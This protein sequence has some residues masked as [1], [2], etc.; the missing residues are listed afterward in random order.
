MLPIDDRAYASLVS[1]LN[2]AY[3]TNCPDSRAAP[4]KPFILDIIGNNHVA[5]SRIA[6]LRIAL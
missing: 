5:L 3:S 4:R 1:S 2:H 6:V